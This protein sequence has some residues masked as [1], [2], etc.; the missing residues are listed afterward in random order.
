[1]PTRTAVGARRVVPGRRGPQRPHARRLGGDVRA[2]RGRRRA[3]SFDELFAP[4]RRPPRPRAALPP[5][6][7][8]RR[9]RPQRAAVDRRRGLRP[10]R[11]HPPLRRRAPRGPR[12]RGAVRAAA[13]RPPAVGV[14]DRARPRATAASGS[15]ARP[16]TAWSTA[17]PRSSSARCC[18]TSSPEPCAPPR[19]RRVAAR[20]P[21]RTRSSCSPAAPGTARASS[22]ALLRAPLA[23][24]RAPLALP[25]FGAAHRPRA[26][27]RRAADRAAQRAQRAR[28]ARAPPRHRAAPARRAARDQARP[29]RDRQRRRC[30]PPSR[31]RCAATPSAASERPRDL[32]AMVPVNV[33]G[34]DAGEL[35]NRITFMFVELPA[36]LA[37]PLDRLHRV[38]VATRARKESGVPEDADAALQALVLRAAHGAEGGRARARQPAR[39]QPRRLQHPRPAD[40][41]V[42]VR[43]PAARGL[44]GR[45]AVGRATRCRSA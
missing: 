30:S 40:P 32:K 35:G 17:S 29:R 37:D 6:D 22:S 11:A 28:L 44:P 23:L 24:A 36:S 31:A 34:D 25:A 4:H 26:R 5:A 15:S 10:R 18:S 8:A 45:P 14:L 43:L 27:R 1:M 33:R 38:S 42:H 19:R 39:L 2:A 13:A 16:T 21:P 41:D 20:R 12:R 9:A 3:P 7:R